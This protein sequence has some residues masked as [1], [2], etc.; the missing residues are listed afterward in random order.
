MYKLKKKIKKKNKLFFR[1]FFSL[2]SICVKNSQELLKKNMTVCL[3]SCLSSLAMISVLTAQRKVNTYFSS[4][5]NTHLFLLDSIDPRWASYSL[6]VFLC[7]RCASL[8]RKMG[9]HISKVK[10]VSM[11]CWTLQEIQVKDS[12]SEKKKCS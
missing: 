5:S 1:F 11:D 7:I 6:G 12:T 2:C 8:H 4:K 3:K 9:T 10:S